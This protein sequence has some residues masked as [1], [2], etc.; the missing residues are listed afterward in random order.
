MCAAYL[1]DW[2]SNDRNKKQ[3]E[4][5][6]KDQGYLFFNID[7]RVVNDKQENGYTSIGYSTQRSWDHGNAAIDIDIEFDR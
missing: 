4:L 5:S 6:Q 2:N 3:G 1:V 7:N